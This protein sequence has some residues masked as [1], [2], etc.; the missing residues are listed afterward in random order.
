MKMTNME[1]EQLRIAVIGLGYVGFP[2]LQ[3]FSSKYRCVGFDINAQ[4]V[5]D[6]QSIIKETY[7]FQVSNEWS[8]IANCNFYIVTVPTPVDSNN[9]PKL[10]ALKNVC[11]NLA[12]LLYQNDIVVFE[13]TVYPG[14]TEEVCVPI[15]QQVSSLTC[16]VD[17]FV[18]Y[19]PERINVG[20]NIHTLENVRKIVS[21]STPRA[22]DVIANVYQSVLKENVVVAS[23]IKIAEAAKMYENVQRD[24]VIALA[25]EFADYCR[26]ESIDINE[27]TDC[28]ATKWNFNDVRPGM[29][30]GHCIGVDPYYLLNR[31][32]I[33][34][35]D[36][37]LVS[38]S[39]TTNEK[40]VTSVA[41]RILDIVSEKESA[42]ILLLGFSYKKNCADIRNTKVAEIIKYLETRGIDVECYDPLVNI[43]QVKR[44]YS[45]SLLPTK[46]DL[47]L[48]DSIII[49][50]NHSEFWE[51]QNSNKFDGKVIH[52][53]N[54][55]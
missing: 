45:I 53:R 54:F 17:F 1:I 41:D 10:T 28:A 30:G 20:D 36:L 27:V 32:A 21:G 13:S 46:P 24:V 42:K 50:V 44:E 35:V 37:P 18:G 11:T 29:V 19:S 8:D 43:E 33:K 38:Q 55:L 7:R 48:Y 39:R 4:K 15:L 40:K 26:A 22:R 5:K 6:L 51:M 47:R 25:N 49:M 2:L 52:L 23:S 31:A 3:L 14:A 9:L 16:N 34:S 12:T